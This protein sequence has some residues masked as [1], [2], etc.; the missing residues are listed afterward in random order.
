MLSSKV[1]PLDINSNQLCVICMDENKAAI[2]HQCNICKPNSWAICKH[3]LLK[4]DK[5][6]ICRTPNNM[7]TNSNPVN[8]TNEITINVNITRNTNYNFSNPRR[9]E[10][11][12][13][14]INFIVFSTISLYLG[15]LCVYS[16]CSAIC[17]KYTCDKYN[18]H[19]FVGKKYWQKIFGWEIVLGA[20]IICISRI[21]FK[22]LNEN[23]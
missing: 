3:C 18:C 19:N 2:N 13:N 11:L 1:C 16:F 4:L 20:F 12:G 14:F 17:H 23:L 9:K 7:L 5:C 15:K 10:I 6:P 22:K 8:P 21:W